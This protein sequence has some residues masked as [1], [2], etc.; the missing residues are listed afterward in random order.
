MIY[1]V[2][3]SC[4]QQGHLDLCLRRRSRSEELSKPALP[5]SDENQGQ[6]APTSHRNSSAK[7]STGAFGGVH[8]KSGAT[9]ADSPFS[10]S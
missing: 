8:S 7:Q 3:R 6:M 10:L 5:G 4:V 9:T 2:F 1:S